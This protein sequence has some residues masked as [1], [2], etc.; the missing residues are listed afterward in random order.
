M[1]GDRPLRTRLA[2]VTV[3]GLLFASA[4]CL[5]RA[6]TSAAESAGP[7]DFARDVRPILQ[8]RCVDCHG[9]AKQKGELRLDDWAAFLKGGS[10][11]PAVVPGKAAESHLI[12]LVAGEDQDAVM[13]PK[14]D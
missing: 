12:R 8:A 7:I 10:T 6:A 4:V 3:A 2:A 13:P 14:G 11:G 5:A 1:P 9:P